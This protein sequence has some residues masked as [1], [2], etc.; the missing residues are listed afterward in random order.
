MANYTQKLTRGNAAFVLVDFLDGF[1]P[2][3]RT[4]PHDLLRKNV[5]AFV[6]LSAIFDMPTIQLGEEG[7]FR[8]EFFTELTEN[9]AHAKAIERHTTSAWDEPEFVKAVEAIDRP[10]WIVGGISID[11]CTTL[12]TI[13][14]L[15]AGYEVYVVT[16]VCGSDSE[17]NQQTAMMR[18]TQAG[19]VMTNWTCVASEIMAD[20]ETPEGP[21]IGAL[22]QE[23]S[24]WGNR[25]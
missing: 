20:W 10:K 24:K 9:N 2:G 6:K 16:D 14:M 15:N 1:L 18:L 3:I 8:G 4:I 5:E 23:L 13:D 21:A 12:L 17:L 7:S 19:A 22:Y 11:I 25:V